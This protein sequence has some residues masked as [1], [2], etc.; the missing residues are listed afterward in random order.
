[1]GHPLDLSY[2]L[3][4]DLQAAQFVRILDGVR[5]AMGFDEEARFDLTL[6]DQANQRTE[7]ELAGSAL[8][9]PLTEAWAQLR[10]LVAANQ[11]IKDMNIKLSLVRRSGG[12]VVVCKGETESQEQAERVVALLQQ[13]VALLAQAG[14]GRKPAVDRQ[15]IFDA[16]PLAAGIAAQARETFLQGD[17]TG[18]LRVA[19]A[20]CEAQCR[21]LFPGAG[22]NPAR[23]EA[24]I[25]RQPPNVPKTEGAKRR[26]QRE[27]NAFAKLLS[28]VLEFIAPRVRAGAKP[29][30]DPAE[31]I[32]Y[33]SLV[34]F[35]VGHLEAC[36][37]AQ[38]RKRKPARPAAKGKAR[39]SRPARL[40]KKI[41]RRPVRRK[42]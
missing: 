7:F 30:G 26:P 17:F 25:R 1:M 29:F 28:G 4:T 37:P 23:L 12:V 22:L 24:A 36:E 6:E 38:P 9:R 39:R 27:W 20:V 34:S 41:A 16:A 40:A 14:P 42:R 31:T 8:A 19:L 21:R 15:L 32:K 13:E 5:Q 3:G 10:Y 35:L 2:R 18:A 33:I 11:W